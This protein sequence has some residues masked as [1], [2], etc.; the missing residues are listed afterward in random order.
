MKVTFMGLFVHE[1]C[2]KTLEKIYLIRQNL[3]IYEILRN[4][5]DLFYLTIIIIIL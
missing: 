3:I 1:Q 4:L 5:E 2:T